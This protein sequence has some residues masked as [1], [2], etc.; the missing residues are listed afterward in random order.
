M[1]YTAEEDGHIE[2]KTGYIVIQPILRLITKRLISAKVQS[3]ILY[4]TVSDY[5]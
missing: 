2:L 1:L 4:S 3:Q 5:K